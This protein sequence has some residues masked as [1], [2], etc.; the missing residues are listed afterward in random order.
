[1]SFYKKNL[2]SVLFILAEKDYLQVLF[3]PLC[4]LN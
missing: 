1:M 4:V 3:L 2:N